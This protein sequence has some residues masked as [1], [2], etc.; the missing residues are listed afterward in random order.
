[1][2]RSASDAA[3]LEAAAVAKRLH[4]QL[5][6]EKR[7]KETG[8]AIDVFEAISDLDIPLVFKEL[9]SAQGLYL[10]RP[11]RGILITTGRSLN[12]QRFTAAHELGHAALDH[13]GS[14]DR[15]IFERGPLQ[16]QNG[17]DL[18]EVAADAFAA[19]FL[20]PRWLYRLHVQRQGWSLAHLKNPDVAY[21]L[22]LRLGASYE[23]TCWGLLNNQILDRRDVA[24]LQDEKVASMKRKLGK[25]Y[26]PTSSWAD[27]WRITERDNGGLFTGTELDLVQL[28]FKE[29][30]SAGFIWDV[31]PLRKAGLEILDD[32]AEFSRDPLVYGAPSIRKIIAR[33]TAAQRIEIRATETQPWSHISDAEVAVTLA[34]NGAEKKGWSRIERIRRGLD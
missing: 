20:L 29:H 17:R 19:E 16:P 32:E 23:A 6:I 34:F 1:M 22:S 26:R 3:R 8:G 11:A 12:I 5:E 24:I 27:V 4:R 2:V 30:S 28:E 33:P 25:G 21:Q 13:E 31:E 10:P 14:I 15:E 7:V 18:K 9:E